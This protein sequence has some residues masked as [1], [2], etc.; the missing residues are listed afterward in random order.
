MLADGEVVLLACSGGPDSTA[1]AV[2]VSHLRPDLA[3]VLAYVAHGLRDAATDAHEAARVATLAQRLEHPHVVLPVEVARTSEGIEADARRARHAAL[4]AEAEHRGARFVLHGHHAEDQAETLLLR[5]ARGTGPDGVAGMAL[6]S[7]RRLRPLLDVRRADAHR[8]AEALLPGVIA[9]ATHDPM[10]DDV[11]LARVLLRR[12]VL[13]GLA[14]IAPDPIGALARFAALT[15]AESELL[16]TMVDELRATLPVVTFGPVTMVRRRE[17]TAL[18]VALARRLVRALLPPGQAR[19]AANVERVLGTEEGQRV[20]IPGPLDVS[21]DRGWLML[22]PADADPDADPGAGA[23]TS[24]TVRLAGSHVHA[25]SGMTIR[26]DPCPAASS[27]TGTGATETLSAELAGGLPP[28]FDA[29]RLTVQLRGSGAL[30]V[31]GR[32]AGDRIRTAG[33]TRMLGDV[34]ADVGVPRA[35]RDL[36]PVVVDAEDRLRWV[37]GVAV[38]VDAHAGTPGSRD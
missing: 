1:L 16:D 13:P 20:T 25:A 7:G 36:L 2:I 28:G 22:R 18:P 26:C 38:D 27:G 11:G 6:A 23:P 17:L 30:G 35:L 10:N 33:G 21:V 32:R 29:A 9:D 37:P 3:L 15:R 31:R 4:E 14:A 19:S 8:A 5:L 12:D 34:L 24:A